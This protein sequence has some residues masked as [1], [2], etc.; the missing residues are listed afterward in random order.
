MKSLN[1]K[2]EINT[3]YG[4]VSV[5]AWYHWEHHG[6]GSYDYWGSICY[7]PAVPCPEI[8]DIIPVFDNDDDGECRANILKYIIKE[9]DD[10][11]EQIAMKL[12]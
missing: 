7:D 6:I 12:L 5:E 10:C 9:Y 8:D 3:P 4:K 2:T 1:Y 11:A